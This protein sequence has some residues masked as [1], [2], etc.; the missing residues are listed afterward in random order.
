M[1]V[2]PPLNHARQFF[3]IVS[4]S[5]RFAKSLCSKELLAFPTGHVMW[6]QNFV[7]KRLILLVVQFFIPR[8]LI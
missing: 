7:R 5:G 1:L 4:I 2:W 3:C 8:I 6:H